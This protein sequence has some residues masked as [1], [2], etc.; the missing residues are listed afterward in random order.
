MP[1]LALTDTE[2]SSMGEYVSQAVA[3]S[4]GKTGILLLNTGLDAFVARAI[5]ATRAERS[6]DVQYYLFHR[7]LSGR[8]LLQQLLLAADRGVRVRLLVD[9]MDMADSDVDLALL[10]AHPNL[11]VRLFNPFAR[12][13][14][15]ASQ[16]L[17]RFGEVTRRMH[18]KSFTADNQLSIIGGRNIGDE[19]FEADPA[20]GFAD[21]DVLLAG[22][23]VKEVSTSFDLY[24][25]H[26]LSYT[27]DSLGEPAATDAAVSQARQNLQQWTA[28]QEYSTYI[29]A[30][31]N[32]DLSKKVEAGEVEWIW[33]DVDIFYD[34]PEKISAD[35]DATYLHLSDQLAS[36]FLNAESVVYIVSPYFVPGKKGT[37]TLCELTSRGVDTR[38][39]TNSLASTDVPIVHAGY[40]RYRKR[41]L[42]C[43]VKIYEA[44]SHALLREVD[45]SQKTSAKSRKRKKLGMSRSS[46]HAKM[47]MFDNRYTFVG[48]MNLDPRS[49][50]ENTEIGAI[51][52]SHAIGETFAESMS[53]KAP[54][55][56]F[57]LTL[58]EDGNI[59]WDGH[60]NGTPVSYSKDPH[61]STW[62]RAKVLLMRFLPI[63]SQI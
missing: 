37:A 9:D 23:A 28:E 54:E 49:V 17:T 19:Y 2:D 11:D 34:H 41:L 40:I 47:Y 3:D 43:G 32:S 45:F 35:R 29:Q 27:V 53:S 4:N 58:D 24:W 48:S 21:V 52:D 16:Y 56:A 51:I 26:A 20:L 62:Q 5:L 59:R 57:V 30:L 12:D 25:N 61:T 42:Q 63:E 15:R 38:V 8:L 50:T 1:S 31:L 44:N 22:P 13:G 14:I 36:Y 18:N 33:A 55:I 6:L 10:D 60:E 7:D 39:L 46:L